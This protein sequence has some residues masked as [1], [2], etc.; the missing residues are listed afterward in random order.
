M[1]TIT[2]YTVTSSKLPS[3][4]HNYKIVHLSDL[5]G[6]S[7]GSGFTQLITP[8]QQLSPNVIVITG[9][10]ITAGGN[11]CEDYLELLNKLTQI[12]PTYYVY[13][14]HEVYMAASKYFS[15]FMSGLGESPAQSLN[16]TH[17]TLTSSKGESITLVGLQD[18]VDVN[19]PIN[20]PTNLETQYLNTSLEEIT[21][22][23]TSQTFNLLLSH[24]PEYF[25]Q[26]SQL[27]IDLILTG[28]AHGGIMQLP[29]VGGLYAPNQGFFPSYTS[30][31]HAI[32]NTT[33]II[34]RG[35]GNSSFP[36]RIFNSPEIGIITL[37]KQLD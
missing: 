21:P 5:H 26:Y 31:Q 16:Q 23:L 19:T 4:F 7:F 15:Y 28:H 9:D 27:P 20:T 24:R 32:N 33:M 17:V 1:I 11:L 13:G 35:L 30:G 25:S 6:R 2:P 36:I 34:N 18:P 14:N 22:Y 10:L 37:K 12:A 3:S 8:I 29:F